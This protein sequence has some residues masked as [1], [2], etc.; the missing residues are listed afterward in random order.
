M[1]I[2][3]RIAS[4]IVLVHPS[5]SSTSGTS[6]EG[7]CF[8][9]AQRIHS[10]EFDQDISA[11]RLR[12][13]QEKIAT[14]AESESSDES[15]LSA[16][17]NA[18]KQARKVA[19]Q[20]STSAARAQSALLGIQ[21]TAKSAIDSV[22]KTTAVLKAKQASLRDLDR[23]LDTLISRKDTVKS[24]D[25]KSE[26]R[27]EMLLNDIDAENRTVTDAIRS[28]ADRAQQVT[29][30]TKSLT[31]LKSKVERAEA[32]AVVS[33]G[34]YHIVADELERSRRALADDQQ[35]L[36]T[37]N[38]KR[39]GQEQKV[40]ELRLQV[41]NDE[42][43][44]ATRDHGV[45]VFRN[46]TLAQAELR[47]AQLQDET[48][49]VTDEL[50]RTREDVSHLKRIQ[51][52]V[53]GTMEMANM[54]SVDSIRRSLRLSKAFLAKEGYGEKFSLLQAVNQTGRSVVSDLD[55]DLN[56]LRDQSKILSLEDELRSLK[57]QEVQARED[58]ESAYGQLRANEAE[59]TKLRQIE[60]AHRRLLTS[61]NQTLVNLTAQISVIDS[62]ISALHDR[63]N[64][65]LAVEQAKKAALKSVEDEKAAAISD[66]LS[67]NVSLVN[68]RASDTESARVVM[69]E[70]SALAKLKQ[71][72]QN[73]T[74]IE[75]AGEVESTQ[76]QTEIGARRNATS[77][78]SDQVKSTL[79]RLESEKK[80][81]TEALAEMAQIT[82]RLDD[83]LHDL[84][85]AQSTVTSDQ[86]AVKELSA[87]IV[88]SQQERSILNTQ[89]AEETQAADVLASKL[90]VMK[91]QAAGMKCSL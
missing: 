82:R 74:T 9:L 63:I 35:M 58:L 71:E 91:N 41:D 45:Q 68:A 22:N 69:E 75:R 24:T 62:G 48:A 26:L 43:E 88:A 90:R 25:R 51:P 29:A 15:D 33:N 61:E 89:L 73:L 70:R 80:A 18:L 10:A 53:N 23:E 81:H 72:Q 79:A 54:A 34:E 59:A 14:A 6:H 49:R 7:E 4:L 36:F 38:R 67:A 3:A 30:L 50:N 21:E 31:V 39:D 20:A 57:E 87:R 2:L 78:L 83:K 13:L 17:V 84:E 65:Q 64:A 66:L 12:A 85:E 76:L 37:A 56:L 40:S 42:V 46:T 77:A 19:A 5:A 44:F 1:S 28:R 11:K 8:N 52:H 55:T 27:L 32:A 60:S 86:T 16:H 47:L